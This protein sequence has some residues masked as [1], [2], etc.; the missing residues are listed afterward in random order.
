MMT[1]LVVVDGIAKSFTLHVQGARQL[2]VFA[3]ISFR[4][5]AGDG[6]AIDGA[7]GAGKSTLLRCLYGNYSVDAGSV[8]VRDRGD[9][10]DIG[11]IPAFA[12]AALRARSIGYVSQFFRA[13]PRVAA[14]DVAAEPLLDRGLPPDDARQTV[15]ALFEA[16]LLPERLWSLSPTTF[17]GGEKQRVNIARTLAADPPVILLDEPTSAL[18]AA[19]RDRVVQLLCERRA[20]GAALIGIYHDPAVRS[21]LAGRSVHLAPGVPA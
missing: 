5:A 6:V 4:V 19:S 1:H 15:A 8:A 21:A 14:I 11:A 9:L 12:L 20:R 2:P 18:D 7:S 16:M 17:S 3:G 10:V 13:V